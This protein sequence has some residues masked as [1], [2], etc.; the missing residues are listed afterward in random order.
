MIEPRRAGPA[1][2]VAV[3]LLVLGT[4]RQLARSEELPAA[5]A[6][7]SACPRQKF[8]VVIDVGHTL[9]VPGAMSARGIPEYA[10]NLQL[11]TQI[12]QMPCSKR[13]LTRPC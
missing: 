11:A 13:A 2:I 5:A 8:Q 9:D 10:F 12:K 6:A 4:G 3:L 7:Q 1:V